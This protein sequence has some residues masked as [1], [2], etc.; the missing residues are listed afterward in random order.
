MVYAASLLIMG[1]L[2]QHLLLDI[3]V[4]S[5]EDNHLIRSLSK[6]SPGSNCLVNSSYCCYPA[7]TPGS[8]GNQ[9]LSPT[10]PG[11]QPHRAR[12]AST[13]IRQMDNEKLVIPGRHISLLDCIGRGM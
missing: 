4:C 13:Y 5:D 9:S 3:L 1:R 10:T 7:N 12:V 11:M 8:P 6:S 2:L